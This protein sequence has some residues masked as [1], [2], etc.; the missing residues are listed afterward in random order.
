M[1][2]YGYVPVCEK[3]QDSFDKKKVRIRGSSFVL[4]SHASRGTRRF[5]DQTFKWNV[6]LKNQFRMKVDT[7]EN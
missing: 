6:E 4:H 7:G 1:K 5:A 3:I 2:D